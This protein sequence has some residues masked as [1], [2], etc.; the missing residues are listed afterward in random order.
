MIR[1]NRLELIGNACIVGSRNCLSR[2]GEFCIASG[3]PGPLKFAGAGA[4]Q[5]MPRVYSVARTK[6]A[7]AARSLRECQVSPGKR[8]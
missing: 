6:A 1:A 3:T 7:P 5:G 4:Q 2:S 8:D